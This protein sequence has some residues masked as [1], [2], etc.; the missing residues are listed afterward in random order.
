MRKGAR[1]RI[2]GTLDVVKREII[3][4]CLWIRMD[5]L[6]QTPTHV[7]FLGSPCRVRRFL[8]Q[9]ETAY[10]LLRRLQLALLL[11]VIKNSRGSIEVFRILVERST[12]FIQELPQPLRLPEQVKVCLDQFRL[13]ER[14]KALLVNRQAL[15]DRAL[16]VLDQCFGFDWKNIVGW[17]F[18]PIG[19]DQLRSSV[20]FL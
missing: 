4:R 13:P 6:Q 20:E 3:A 2:I 18:F 9:P 14:L 19:H 10:R 1:L 5:I 8:V 16:F 17:K 7:E 12:S 15:S 11:V